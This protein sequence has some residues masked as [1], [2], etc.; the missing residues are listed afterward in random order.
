[1]G[2]AVTE[3]PEPDPPRMT[4][5]PVLLLLHLRSEPF[6]HRI[7]TAAS[8]PL[9]GARGEHQGPLLLWRPAF[10]LQTRMILVRLRDVWM[11]L[12]SRGAAQTRRCLRAG[13][14]AE[15]D[16]SCRC[17]CR[18]CRVCS[19]FPCNRVIS[20]VPACALRAM[21]AVVLHAPTCALSRSKVLPF[22]GR[23]SWPTHAHSSEPGRRCRRTV[24]RHL[25]CRSHCASSPVH[26]YPC[27]P[28]LGQ[29]FAFSGRTCARERTHLSGRTSGFFLSNLCTHARV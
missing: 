10:E 7:F 5:P 9:A 25:E 23:D 16:A 1:M 21:A 14:R 6:P 15:P 29:S 8:S 19:P 28:P 4:L 18:H 12:L 26:T 20:F 13:H 24:P 22:L 17:R 3:K 2:A 27:M 11:S